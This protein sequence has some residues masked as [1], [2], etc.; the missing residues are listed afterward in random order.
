[1]RLFTN[2][3]FLFFLQFSW[4]QTALGMGIVK[5]NFNDQTVLNFF[6]SA[7]GDEPVQV[8]EFFTDATIHSWNIRNLE[9]Q[10]EWL[11]PELLWLDYGEFN[12]RCISRFEDCFELVVNNQT[13][14]TLWL[15]ASDIAQF[16][17]WEEYLMGMFSV[18]RLPEIPQRIYSEPDDTSAEIPYEG[19]DCFAVKSLIGNWIEITTPDYC[20]GNFEESNT[21]FKRGWI[22][23]REG[24]R[25][26]IEYF[27]TS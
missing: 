26:L 23:W 2:T 1:M 27:T 18:R 4:S 16:M 21:S 6:D 3:L 25:L 14:E 11:K 20:D 22:K 8:I 19:Q 5:I 9:A 24:N 7:T 15:R 10:Q 12:F 17:T 13:G